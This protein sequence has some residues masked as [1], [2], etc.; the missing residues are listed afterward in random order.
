M[1]PQETVY[2]K[3]FTKSSLSIRY[4]SLKM[5]GGLISP[6][7]RVNFV[8]KE[9]KINKVNSNRAHRKGWLREKRHRMAN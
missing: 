1:R 6:V 9:K 4:T 8:K 7:N 2:H 5:V 3:E